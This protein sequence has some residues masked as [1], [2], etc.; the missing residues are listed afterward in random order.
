VPK[1]AKRI[2]SKDET[3]SVRQF[4]QKQLTEASSAGE[5]ISI[6]KRRAEYK[7]GARS[8]ST[9]GQRRAA[10]ARSVKAEISRTFVKMS[11]E[12]QRDLAEITL[13]R[14]PGEKMSPK[15]NARLGEIIFNAGDTDEARAEI[16]DFLGSPDV[17]M[18]A[19]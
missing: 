16:L 17:L 1:D 18:K 11:P 7:A 4:Q 19:A 12:D 2:R 5:R 15:E 8:Y 9:P 6:E 14:K 10:R 3:I 13:R